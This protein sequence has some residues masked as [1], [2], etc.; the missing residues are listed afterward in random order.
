ME[1]KKM[2]KSEELGLEIAENEKEALWA[3]AKTRTQEDIKSLKESLFINEAF[4]R[5]CES[6]LAIL[7]QQKT[8]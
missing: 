8:S 2:I 3:K 6:E 5:M 4:L 7:D 1:T